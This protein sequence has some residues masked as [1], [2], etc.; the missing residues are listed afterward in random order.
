VRPTDVEMTFSA[1]P[2][3]QSLQIFDAQTARTQFEN[4][5]DGR[6]RACAS[7][8]R[9]QTDQRRFPA[10]PEFAQH[11]GGIELAAKRAQKPAEWRLECFE[12]AGEAALRELGT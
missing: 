10:F 2:N 6:V 9:F 7:C 5:V 4:A 3:R 1:H 8:I 12:T 11:C